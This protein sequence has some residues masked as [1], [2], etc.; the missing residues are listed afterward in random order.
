[1]IGSGSMKTEID[2]IMLSPEFNR[3]R[4]NIT[5]L[6]ETRDL[7]YLLDSSDILVIPS[8]SEGFPNVLL[9][10]WS[11]GLPVIASTEALAATDVNRS[12]VL[13][14]QNNRNSD[15]ATKMVLICLSDSLRQK[16]AEQ[17]A[18]ILSEYDSSYVMPQWHDILN[19]YS[20]AK[21]K[22]NA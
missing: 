11:V 9:E 8:R 22:F 20:N 12:S 16:L 18:I 7:K 4:D 19:T 3:I 17:S 1:M 5:F 10:A 6:G 21:H 15:L 13:L 2:N 14:Y